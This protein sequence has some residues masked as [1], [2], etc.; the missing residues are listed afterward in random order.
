ML[1]HGSVSVLP[2]FHETKAPPPINVAFQP[3]GYPFHPEQEEIQQRQRIFEPLYLRRTVVRHLIE[4][5]RRLNNQVRADEFEQHLEYLYEN[6]KFLLF[7]LAKLVVDHF[8]REF[9]K[10]QI[11][12]LQSCASP[13]PKD[14]QNLG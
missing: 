5:A 11:E 12:S 13:A 4:L 2:P 9:R 8:D 14:F 1:L 6:Y 10:A 3:S 7:V